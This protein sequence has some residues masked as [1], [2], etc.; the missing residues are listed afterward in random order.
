MATVVVRAE[1]Q[2]HGRTQKAIAVEAVGEEVVALIM[3]LTEVVRLLLMV[4]YSIFA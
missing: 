3:E 2:A 4:I 1:V